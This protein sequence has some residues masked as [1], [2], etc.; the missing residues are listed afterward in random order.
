MEETKR[1]L[2]VKAM[3]AELHVFP[4]WLRR[5]ANDGL[6][7]CIEGSSPMAFDADEVWSRIEQVSG[8][9]RNGCSCVHLAGAVETARVIGVSREDLI[10]LA[11]S[12]LVPH[13]VAGNKYMFHL[14][15]VAQLDFFDK[16]APVDPKT[17]KRKQRRIPR[18]K[19]LLG[20][21]RALYREAQ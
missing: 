20:A 17:G 16:M 15:T 5:R 1:I 8:Y 12:G 14:D 19:Q 18:P 3:A 9:T 10:D 6:L 7:P 2:N 4:A 13:F 21:P 11:Q